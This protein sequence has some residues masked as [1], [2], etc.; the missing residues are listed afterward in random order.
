[1]PISKGQSR[2]QIQQYKL[3]SLKN[4][5]D[6]ME[7][8]KH[9]FRYGVTSCSSF[10]GV[11]VDYLEGHNETMTFP[12][13]IKIDHPRYMVYNR[14]IHR[15]K[16]DGLLKYEYDAGFGCKVWTVNEKKLPAGAVTYTGVQHTI[17][18]ESEPKPDPQMSAALRALDKAAGQNE[19]KAFV[20]EELKQITLDSA[21]ILRKGISMELEKPTLYQLYKLGLTLNETTEPCEETY[22]HTDEEQTQ[23]T[24]SLSDPESEPA[25]QETT[26]DSE[27]TKPF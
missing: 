23:P 10:S 22:E 2:K 13:C 1:M 4:I 3:Q 18:M 19:G 14:L 15:M 9:K 24:P 25:Y 12:E 7:R 20:E 21:I 27:T 6:W 17:P 26:P 11:V 5:Y 16:A 8:N